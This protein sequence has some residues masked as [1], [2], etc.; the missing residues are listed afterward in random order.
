[1]DLQSS[2]RSRIAAPFFCILLC[3]TSS[4]ATICTAAPANSI[5]ALAED[6][7]WHTLLH[8]KR[9]IF[10]QKSTI[11][12]P[13]FFLSPEGATNPT[14]E[15]EATVAAFSTGDPSD[16]AHPI[17]RFPARL[18]WLQK[19]LAP[20]HTARF[21]AAQSSTFEEVWDAMEPTAASVIF[22]TQY[23]N[24]PASLFGHTLINI[25]GKRNEKILAYSINYS[26]ITEESN[27]LI[28][29]V[30]GIFGYYPG[31]F[32]ID[33]YYQKVQQYSDLS[34]RDIW[35]YNLNL[36]QDEVRNLILHLWE[37]KDAYSNYFFFKENCSYNLLF[38]LDAARP[39]SNMVDQFKHWVIPVDTIKEVRKNN[40]IASEHYRPSRSTTIK[41]IAST[42]PK[43]LQERSVEATKSDAASIELTKSLDNRE[44]KIRSLDLSAELL[45]MYH[46]DGKIDQK[47]Y[48]DRFL[49]ILKQRAP[50]G[51]V[52]DDF[53]PNTTPPPPHMG[54]DSSRITTGFGSYDSRDF[55]SFSLRP[56][57]HDLM[58]PSAGYTL[59]SAIE[60][61]SGEFYYYTDEQKLE[62]RQLDAISIQSLSPIDTFFKSKSWTL[63]TGLTTIK[64]KDSHDRHTAIYFDAG[65]GV[66]VSLFDN[67]IG[68]ALIEPA[69]Y[70]NKSLASNHMAGG[71]GV[72]G[73]LSKWTPKWRSQF[74]I[75]QRYYF[76]G[77]DNNLTEFKAKAAYSLGDTTALQVSFSRSHE[78][79][80]TWNELRCSFQLF[81]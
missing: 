42:L 31:R 61:L 58:D 55:I 25:E 26:A 27:G 52:D 4:L 46:A 40:F 74:E 7:Y 50:L 29:A 72:V 14:A 39:A 49:T 17:N 36:N 20:E 57:Y 30:K 41:R 37:L 64:E 75:R 65:V 79:E 33:P 69:I 15:L 76:L 1:M 56:A 21:V 9:T 71:G 73:L 34:M 13:K 63:N 6:D 78:F 68:Y 18:N 3:M 45:Q 23:M 12:D 44:D 28:F 11:D 77:E 70:L 35:E 59:G 43:E 32:S 10:S 67:S 48:A 16:E 19:N 60:F 54:H 62:V 24:N 66:S 81:F 2:G 80:Q 47:T 53:Y 38:L 22:P 8:Y 51:K 5:G